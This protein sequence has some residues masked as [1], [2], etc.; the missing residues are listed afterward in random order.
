MRR[1]GEIAPKLVYANHSTWTRS[2]LGA[3]LP[4]PMEILKLELPTAAKHHAWGI[5][6]M[7]D[8]AWGVGAAGNYLLARQMWNA[9]IDVEET[10][11][12]W[13]Q[14]AYGPGWRISATSIHAST[15]P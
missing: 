12:E 6:M 4:I 10:L 15:R 14:R 13:L 1:W 9:S 11:D 3:P 5:R 7:G 8:G 2:F